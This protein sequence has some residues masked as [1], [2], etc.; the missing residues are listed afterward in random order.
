MMQSALPNWLKLIWIVLAPMGILFAWR[1][2]WERM[3]WTWSRGPQAVGS[4]LIHTHPFFAISGA[5]SCN[6][7]A[8]WLI[9]AGVCIVR[10]REHCSKPD[11][12]MVVLSLIAALVMIVS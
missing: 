7:L 4:S 5:V 6:L 12:M 10:R 1:I 2:A 3:V 11:V 8:L 9:T